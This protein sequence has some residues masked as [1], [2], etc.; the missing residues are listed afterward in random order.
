M[1]WGHWSLKGFEEQNSLHDHV[2]NHQEQSLSKLFSGITVQEVLR[3]FPKRPHET[4]P[5]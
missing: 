2:T 5:L 3:K 1:W 4:M